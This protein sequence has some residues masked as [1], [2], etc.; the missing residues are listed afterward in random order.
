VTP[1]PEAIYLDSRHCIVYAYYEGEAAGIN[2]YHVM[3]N[4]KW[5]RGWVPFHDSL[6]G[7]RFRGVEG[8][9]GWNVIQ[10][11]PLTLTPS[12]ACRACCN[13]GHITNGKWVPA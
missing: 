6:W 12:I 10:R 5:C 9:E 3:P 7:K 11:E 13:H 4:G 8:W 2:E 1:P